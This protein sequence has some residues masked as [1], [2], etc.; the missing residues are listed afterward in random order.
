MGKYILLMQKEIIIRRDKKM[1]THYKKRVVKKV[2]IECSPLDHV[3]RWYS[4]I[5]KCHF[6]L[7]LMSLMFRMN[8]FNLINHKHNIKKKKNVS[9]STKIKCSNGYF[10]FNGDSNMFSILIKRCPLKYYKNLF[11]KYSIIFNFD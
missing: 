11:E 8:L 7:I 5:V 4:N 1:F 9:M 3:W 2:K 6:P 10:I